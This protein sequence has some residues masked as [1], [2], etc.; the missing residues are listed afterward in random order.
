MEIVYQWVIAQMNEVPQD[1]SL[2]DVVVTIHWTRNATTV[3]NDIV[4]TASTYGAYSCPLPSGT[5][6]T[7]YDQLTETQVISWL[8]A[9]LDIEAIN[10]NLTSQ[11]NNQITPPII[12]LPLPWEPTTTTT[13]T[14]IA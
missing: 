13:T 10:M 3:V 1:G 5:D 12:I 7:P 8:D 4:Y 11:L 2:T 6:F 9:G 14:T